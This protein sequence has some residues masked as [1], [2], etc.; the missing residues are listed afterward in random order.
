MALAGKQSRSR[1]SRDS[2][3]PPKVWGDPSRKSKDRSV[4]WLSENPI[5]VCFAPMVG[6]LIKISALRK[7]C[8]RQSLRRLRVFIHGIANT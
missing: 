2:E 8:A 3:T 7:Q 5:A 6:L 4:S 1:L